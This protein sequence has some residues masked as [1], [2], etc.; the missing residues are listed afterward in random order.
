MLTRLQ[1]HVFSVQGA[2]FFFRR[3]VFYGSL[4]HPRALT[5]AAG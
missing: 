5:I 1:A 4:R 2:K 3:R